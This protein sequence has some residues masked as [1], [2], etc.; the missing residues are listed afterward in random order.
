[1][2]DFRITVDDDDANREL[3]VIATGLADLRLFWPMLVPVV[4]GW[5]RRQFESQG[6]FAGAPWAPLSPAYG[7]WKATKRPGKPILQ[8]D[9]DMKDAVSR[10][11][12][13]QTPI[14]LTLSVD[15][16][17]LGYHQ[18]GKGSL[19]KREVIFGDPLPPLAALELDLVAEQYVTDLIGR[20]RRR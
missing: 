8:F 10:P 1:M 12:R 4:T 16:P 5:W 11:R 19:P 20:A 9:G 2:T 3:N 13:S 15:D 7:A 18:E 14:S 6:A 17:K